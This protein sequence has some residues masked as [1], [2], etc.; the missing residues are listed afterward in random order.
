[1]TECR[2]DERTLPQARRS[3]EDAVVKL[4]QPQ[5]RVIAEKLRTA[6][7][8]YHQLAGELAGTQG[9][10]HTPAKSIPPLWI[11]ATQLL[12][13]IDTQT[14]RWEPRHNDTPARLSQIAHRSWRPQDVDLVS[15][16]ASQVSRWCDSIDKLLEPEHVKHIAD[17]AC[18]SCN[19]KHFYRKDSAGDTVRQPTLQ[20]ITSQGCECVAC[21]A[22]WGPEKYLFLCKLLGFDMPDGV[23]E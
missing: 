19:K 18:P 6:P 7:S 17:A 20:I 4:V 3:L 22:Y 21:G 8:R 15:L 16:I 14:R 10:T 5:H 23:L 2:R 11:D 1:M 9:D 12:A 13:D